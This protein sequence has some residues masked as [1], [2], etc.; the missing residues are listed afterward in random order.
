M[1][2]LFGIVPMVYLFF[3]PVVTMGLIARENSLGTSEMI[4]TLPIRD[5]EFV[6][7]KYLAAIT[8]IAAGLAFT[9]V[10]FFTLL[11]VGA[12]LDGSDNQ[13]I[14]LPFE[15]VVTADFEPLYLGLAGSCEEE[16]GS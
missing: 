11:A 6:V 16:Q 7:G 5:H 1:R 10:H 9:F 12:D 15:A 2:S 3:C 8:L 4:A 14:A 13:R